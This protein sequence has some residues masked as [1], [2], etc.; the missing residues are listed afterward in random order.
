MVTIRKGDAGRVV[1][2]CEDRPG[3]VPRQ[4]L[5]EAWGRKGVDIY[6]LATT[7]LE[8][9][10]GDLILCGRLETPR[11]RA[12]SRVLGLHAIDSQE[13]P[14]GTYVLRWDIV[15]GRKVFL[16]LGRELSGLLY[17][18]EDLTQ[19]ATFSPEGLIY[20]GN[21]K[22][23]RPALTYRLLWT[24]DHSTNWNLG[25]EG[26]LDWGCMNAY[27][28][29]AGAFVDDYK[30]LID[31]ASRNRFNGLV[32]WGFLRDAHGG[33]E[34]AQEICRFAQDRGV[35]IL[36]GVGTSFYGGFYYKGEHPFN[37]DVWLRRHPEY[38]ARDKAGNPTNRLCPSEPA[39]QDWLRE[40]THWLFETFDIGGVEW[41]FHGL[42]L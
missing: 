2:L 11:W 19:R 24:W 23:E 33:V 14:P 17:A 26:Q 21:P 22:V 6:P 27:L 28:K 13:S 36:V 15:E 3:G 18:I 29:P 30:R 7:S 32:I 16:C 41:R 40:G 37:V 34:A 9:T 12:V 1:I 42:L 39:N 25:Y 35:R 38:A 4:R 8:Y 5:V 31:W 20:D 10:D